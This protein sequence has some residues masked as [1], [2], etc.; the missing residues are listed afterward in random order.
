MSTRRPGSSSFGRSLAI[1]TQPYVLLRAFVSVCGAALLLAA[2]GLTVARAR[3]ERGVEVR[4]PVVEQIAGGDTH[5][6][7]IE[8]SSGQYVSILVSKSDLNLSLSLTGPDGRVLYELIGRRFGPLRLALITSAAGTYRVEVRSLEGDSVLRQYELRV[9]RAGA[10]TA[11]DAK[12]QL[13]TAT[14][15]EAE[16]LREAWTEE[17]LRAAVAEYEKAVRLWRSI[18]S[19]REAA[20]A[21]VALGET[22]VILGDY[23]RAL[24]AYGRA[25]ALSHAANDREGEAHAL[26]QL[27]PCTPAAATRRRR[28]S[29]LA[30]CAVC[31]RRSQSPRRPRARAWRRRRSTLWARLNTHR[32][33]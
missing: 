19:R 23:P 7:E 14:Y 30:R 29:A 33:S 32:G 17:S 16:R 15:A 18:S 12:D 31:W 5:R 6:Y 22:F 28:L 8:L 1:P 2:D 9:E 21:L 3:A 11:R 24:G 27:G 13:A 4:A 25:R 10:A 20:A 26:N